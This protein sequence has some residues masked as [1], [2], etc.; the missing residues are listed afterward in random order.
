MTSHGTRATSARTGPLAVHA[1]QARDLLAA[2]REAGIGDAES[3]ELS[4]QSETTLPEAV[5]EAVARIAD[6]EAMVAALDERA[7]QIAARKVALKERAERI[8]GAVVAA[9]EL[10]GVPRVE[11]P[12]GNVYLVR[13]RPGVR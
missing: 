13:G 8:R 7:D 12:E 11:T 6:L 3:A 2:L 1:A 4:L 9:L 10:A 5:G